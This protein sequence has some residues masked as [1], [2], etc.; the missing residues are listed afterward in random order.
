MSGEGF[1][2]WSRRKR[3]WSRRPR[4]PRPGPAAPQAAAPAAAPP[5]E[6]EFDLSSLPSLE[7]LTAESDFTAF[8]RPQV[9]WA[10]RQAALR[11]MWSLDV[12]IRDFVGPADYAWDFNAPDGVPGFALELGGD[13]KRLLAQAIG[14][15]T[16]RR[17][18]PAR[19]RPIARRGRGH[20]R[21]HAPEET[22]E[23]T[24]EAPRRPA[25][26]R[27]RAGAMP[28]RRRASPAAPL[29]EAPALLAAPPSP[30]RLSGAALPA[31][32]VTLPAPETA[33]A[34]ASPRRRHGG[35]LPS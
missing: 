34:E 35:A 13:V 6:P 25:R 30:L 10:L 14:A 9:P 21:G 24:G 2:R 32:P 26:R 12:G 31:A 11:R 23:E 4:N 27:G 18:S 16:R 33:A 7:S 5:A 20:G 28:W 22:A 3:G 1:S 17:R 29:A 15:P 8:L 19:P